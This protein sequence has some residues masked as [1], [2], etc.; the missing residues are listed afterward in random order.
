MTHPLDE[1]IAEAQRAIGLGNVKLPVAPSAETIRYR[2]KWTRIHKALVQA[3][4]RGAE[5]AG[6]TPSQYVEPDGN[7]MDA[8]MVEKRPRPGDSEWWAIR[9][10]S[11]VWTRGGV[12][13]H[14]PIPSSR[15]DA[16]MARARFRWSEIAAE[17]RK[18]DVARIY[19]K[20][21]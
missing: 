2:E 17:F 8:I 12:W 9:Q 14:E 21:L 10:L 11:N 4:E 13:E 3:R 18:A 20:R 7:A 19:P 5:L 6:M 16:F 15:D 1:A